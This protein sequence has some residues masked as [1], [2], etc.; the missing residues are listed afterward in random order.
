VKVEP[1]GYG[2]LAG[3]QGAG[4]VFVAEHAGLAMSMQA[5]RSAA[6]SATRARAAQAEVSGPPAAL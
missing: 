4:E 5:G 3:A 2:G 1:D 6:G